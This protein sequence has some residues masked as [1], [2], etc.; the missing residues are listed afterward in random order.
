MVLMVNITIIIVY[1]QKNELC[2]TGIRYL[3]WKFYSK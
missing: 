3:T 2:K 1:L